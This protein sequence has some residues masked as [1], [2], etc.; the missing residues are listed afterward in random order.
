[1]DKS[2]WVC[3]RAVWAALATM[4]AEII[5]I[6][7]WNVSPSPQRIR[8]CLSCRCLLSTGKGDRLGE[9][10]GRGCHNSMF[11]R[12]RQGAPVASQ[13]VDGGIQET[14]L[15]GIPV[16]VSRDREMYCSD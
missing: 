16:V 14:R 2:D 10:A 4:G 5:T 15:L 8:H 6:G 11:G 1:M 12:H 3:P 7:N 9:G 13:I